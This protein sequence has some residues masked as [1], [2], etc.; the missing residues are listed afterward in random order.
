MTSPLK[1]RMNSPSLPSP[2]SRRTTPT[3]VARLPASHSP[4]IGLLLRRLLRRES[5]RRGRNGARDRRL[6]VPMNSPADARKTGWQSSR[7]WRRRAQREKGLV[8]RP[9][10]RSCPTV[11]PLHLL[12]LL[13]FFSLAGT[14]KNDVV[15]I[16]RMR[17]LRHP[18]LLY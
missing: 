1:N 8:R 14:V 13:F 18:L 3:M 7:G 17:Y 12:P 16:A 15:A 9:Q 11:S 6:R 5:S 4:P 10:A 2:D